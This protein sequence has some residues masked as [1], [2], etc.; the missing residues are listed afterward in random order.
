M[1]GSVSLLLG[2]VF[3]LAL[4]MQQTGAAQPRVFD[5]PKK[6]QEF[7]NQQSKSHN[8]PV[9]WW[10]MHGD[11][12]HLIE[13]A[14]EYSKYKVSTRV[15]SLQYGSVSKSSVLPKVVHTEW[16]H[17]SQPTKPIVVTVKREKT[18]THQYS[19]QTQD[20]F[21][22]GTS[23]SIEAGL[24]GVADVTSSFSATVSLTNTAGQVHTDAEKYAVD[25]G[26][27][28]PPMKSAKIEWVITDVTQEI[29]WTA[30]IDIEGWFAVWFREKVGDH[31]LWFYRVNVLKD[32]LLKETEEGVRY[33]ARGIFKGVHGS[34]S[35]LRV[36]E[37]DIG[38]YGGKPT[39][40]YTIPL[41]SPRLRSG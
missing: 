3:L 6:I 7:V 41:P 40:V 4:A 21:S 33:T 36:S 24:P 11:H 14:A 19:W 27:T 16:A 39:K 22:V 34:D 2:A 20:T 10:N 26:V 5:L 25:L 1:A 18:L 17:N 8:V 32:P 31:F 29:P 13:N 38:A 12:S 37:Y 35:Q 15:G 28:V 30:Q 23:V 9:V